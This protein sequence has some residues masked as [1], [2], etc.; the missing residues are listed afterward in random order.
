MTTM[1]PKTSEAVKEEDDATWA[2]FLEV[3]FTADDLV[4]QPRKDILEKETEIKNH[5]AM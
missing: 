4:E 3:A 1:L 2:D 5:M